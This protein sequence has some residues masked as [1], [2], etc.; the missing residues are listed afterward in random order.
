MRASVVFRGALSAVLATLAAASA[1]AATFSLRAVKV[2]DLAVPPAHEITIE[3]GDRVTAEVWITACE[4]GVRFNVTGYWA[5]VDLESG[6][7]SG[8]FGMVSAGVCDVICPADV[9]SETVPCPIYYGCQWDGCCYRSSGNFATI[10]S[11]HPEYLFRDCVSNREVAGLCDD[12]TLAARADDCPQPPD[13]CESRY[14]GTVLLVA[15][16]YACGMFVFGFD[17]SACLLF[18][19]AV[20]PTPVVAK[21]EPLVV[22]VTQCAPRPM[23][24]NP[25]H[26]WFDAR[27]PFRPDGVWIPEDENQ[28]VM[29]FTGP[30]TGMSTADFE[31]SVVSDDPDL[32]APLITSVVPIG[33]DVVITLNRRVVRGS[34]TCVRHKPS[35]SSCSRGSLPVDANG[36][37]VSDPADVNELIA[38]LDGRLVGLLAIERCD[39]DR[40]RVC[41]PA[42]LL[43]A[44]DILMGAGPYPPI[45]GLTLP[46]CPSMS[47]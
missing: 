24:C 44:V 5:K 29:Q 47:P 12:F 30:P 15:S 18:L 2:N 46:T 34:W 19:D 45:L 9:C 32:G 21:F 33:N 20:P 3:P 35:G 6:S 38:N 39:M 13:Q 10:D 4:P 31:V 17:P 7:T 36:D 16:A 43:T 40:S 26:C 11:A 42:D 8:E 41:A 37:G 22:T 1:Q 28:F 14:A 25:P 23:G 27:T